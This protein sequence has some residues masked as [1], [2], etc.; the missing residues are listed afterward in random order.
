VNKEKLVVNILICLILTS[1]FLGFYFNENSAGAGNYNG[2]IQHTWK[3]LQI[4]L[5]NN[6]YNSINSEEYY[7][8]RTPLVF[9]LHKY[10]N[11]FTDNIETYRYSIFI[12]SLLIPVLLFIALKKKFSKINS[13]LLILLSCITLLSPYVRTS[14]FWGLEENFSI[15]SLILSYIFLNLSLVNS[16]EGK[17]KYLYLFFLCLLSSSCLYFDYKFTIITIICFAEIFFSKLKIKYKIF[18]II[19]YF[20]LS[21][22]F[23][24]FVILWGS[25]FSIK[26]QSTQFLGKIIFWDNLGFALTIVGF[27]MLPFYI[28]L[29]KKFYGPLNKF[30][31]FNVIILILYIIFIEFFYQAPE[32]NIHTSIGGGFIKKITHLFF[33]KKIYI[34]IFYYLSFIFSFLIIYFFLNNNFY[35]WRIILYFL[36]LSL[37]IHPLLQEYYD[38]LI[39]LIIL[40]FLKKNFFINLNRLIVIFFYFFGLLISSNIYYLLK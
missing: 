7:S 8:N 34:K 39:F 18:T 1:F 29:K 22:P 17:K 9:I 38:P 35:N 15:I 20:I 26:A 25:I 16:N 28:L 21:L 14:A 31:I 11:P 19:T 37:I 5:N 40:L 33:E 10:F 27:Y 6:L 32:I 3:N 12:I 24:Y 2:D 30:F 23:F 4:F 13:S 36:I